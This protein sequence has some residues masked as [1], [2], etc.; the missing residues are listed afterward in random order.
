LQTWGVG[1]G[2]PSVTVYDASMHV[3]AHVTASGTSGDV[4]FNVGI[5]KPLSKYYVEVDDAPTTNFGIGDYVLQVGF[6]GPLAPVTNLVDDVVA[7]VLK[8]APAQSSSLSHPIQI[9]NDPVAGDRVISSLTSSIPQAFYQVQR[10]GGP[11]GSTQV[12][13]VSVIALDPAGV[14]PVVNVFDSKGNSV[15]SQVLAAE[16]GAFVVQVTCSS[17]VS[18]YLIQVKGGAL[19]LTTWTGAYYLDATF[20]SATAATQSIAS[21]APGSG[22]S[23]DLS[24]GDD[25]LFRFVLTAGSGNASAG[26]RVTIK[27]ASGHVLASASVYAGQSESLT[28]LL[29]A[30]NYTIYVT[31]ISPLGLVPPPSF[32]LVG[33]GLSDPIKA[34]SSG[35]GSTSPPVLPK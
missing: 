9:H 16:G 31:A 20:S 21:G 1:I 2:Q 11:N 30:G 3:V 19:G 28:L 17:S 22:Q 13:T 29:G 7:S 32:L 12:M 5:L 23:A 25:E 15:A 10:P 27:D 34:Y 24:L 33:L 8:P 14:T 26:E 18:S 35:S 6:S 4:S